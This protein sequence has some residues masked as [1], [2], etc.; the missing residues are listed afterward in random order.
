[1]SP[2]PSSTP[3]SYPF[4]IVNA[5]SRD[6]F[7]GNPATVI[8]L[9]PSNTLT[10]EER[11]KFA[12]GFNQPI[13]VF[14]TPNL[15]ALDKPGV[16]SFDV[17]YF[18]PTSEWELCGHGTIAAMKAVFDSATNSPGFGQEGQFP[19]FASPDTHTIEFKTASDV[20]ITAHKVVIEGEDWFEIAL[21]AAKL[22]DLSAEEERRVLEKY[23]Q[24]IGR[25]PKVRYIGTAEPPFQ[26][27]LL[28][29]LEESESLDQL[30]FSDIKALVSKRSRTPPHSPGPT[31]LTNLGCRRPPA[32]TTK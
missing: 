27:Y 31:S 16:V 32:L 4:V 11:L 29:V 13:V 24:A 3:R 18:T 19:A 30:E 28:V 15:L 26:R 7:G 23:T 21:P 8:F 2:I 1:M 25:E 14:L 5:F 10:K 17:Q 20:A 6:P 12:K 9:E 22:K